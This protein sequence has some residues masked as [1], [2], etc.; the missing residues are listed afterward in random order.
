MIRCFFVGCVPCSIHADSFLAHGFQIESTMGWMNRYQMNS[1]TGATM[2]GMQTM[3]S[4]FSSR[5]QLK[6]GAG[7]RLLEMMTSMW[8]FHLNTAIR[9]QGAHALSWW[10]CQPSFS[11]F[12][13][14][15]SSTSV[16]F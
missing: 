12:A 15:F 1:N 6:N 14:L 3:A 10:R 2:H 9:R 4:L 11:S 13:E 7:T 16:R 5:K 8:V